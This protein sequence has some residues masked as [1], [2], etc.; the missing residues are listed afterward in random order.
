MSIDT[1]SQV[2][3]L[4][5]VSRRA[6]GV[7]VRRG[8]RAVALHYG[9]AAGELAACVRAVGLADCSDLAKFVLEGAEDRL[10][11]LVRRVAGA[12]LA[13][14]GALAAGGAWWC[15]ESAERVIVICEPGVG[16]RLWARLRTSVAPRG[17]VRLEDRSAEIAA[18]AVAGRRT[19]ALL[20]QLGVYGE[21]GDPRLVPPLTGC[22]IAGADVLWLLQSDR[23]A[24]AL[25]AAEAATAV[26][27]E[28]DRAGQAHGIC[29]VGRDALTRYG[30]THGLIQTL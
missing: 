7:F 10:R 4:D 19:T 16:D 17:S 15:A 11:V 25:V 24:L 28:L 21:A 1:S 6:G 2:K 8:E 29:A 22:R 9:S 14:G 26:W 23:R 13:P 30:L 18:V 3:T 27:R 5:E 20:A 12:R